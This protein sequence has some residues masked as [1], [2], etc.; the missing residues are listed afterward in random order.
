MH[1]LNTKTH[2]EVLQSLLAETAKA[3]NELRCL[4][5]DAQKVANRLTFVV[6]AVNELLDRENPNETR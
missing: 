6:A 4:K 3:S 2:Q 1:V 5:Q